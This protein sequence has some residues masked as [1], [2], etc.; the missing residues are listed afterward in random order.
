MQRCVREQ[1]DGKS[2]PAHKALYVATV[3]DS[4]DT[5]DEASACPTSPAAHQHGWCHS[6]APA[7]QLCEP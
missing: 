3:Q 5:L 7:L 1:V 4:S 2:V 6:S